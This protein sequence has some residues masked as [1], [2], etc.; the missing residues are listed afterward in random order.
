MPPWL[1]EDLRASG[2][3]LVIPGK[4][5]RKRKIRHDWPCYSER[6]RLEA[7]FNRL[8]NFHRIA[9]RY[10]KLAR[11][12]A[13]TVAV[14]IIVAGSVLLLAEPQTSQQSVTASRTTGH[15]V[16]RQRLALDD[17]SEEI[18]ACRQSAAGTHRSA[19]SKFA[20]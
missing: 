15:S 16:A 14:A 20:N 12:Y 3:T 2:I 4:R 13:S 19:I 6:G 5:G 7:I 1:R 10:E 11:N 17:H 9:T 18:P 8:K